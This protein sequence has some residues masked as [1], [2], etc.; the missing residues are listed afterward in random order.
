MAILPNPLDLVPKEL[1]PVRQ[2]RVM[3]RFVRRQLKK[4]GLPPGTVVHVG[5]KKEE[6]SRVS[7][8]DFD[9]AQL[10][11]REDVQDLSVL[12]ALRES[13]TVSWVNVDGLHDTELIERLGERLGLHPLV[14]EDIAHVGQRPKLEEYDEYLYIVL[15]QLEWH[16]E[17]EM[18]AEEQ[19]SLVLGT[20]WMFSFQEQRGDDFDPT[21]E[22][23]RRGQ[24]KLR[25]R[26][27]DYLAYTLLDAT[28]DNYFTILNHIGLVTEQLELELLDDPGQHTMRKLQQLTREL[29]VVRRAVWPLRDV[30]T[31]LM[32]TESE[33]IREDTR[34]YLRDVHDHALR[35]LEAVETLRDVVSG[36]IDLYL[37]QVAHRTN[38]AIKVLT[39]M[40]GIFIPL[41]FI[42]G[43]YGM[44]FVYMP[45]LES[46]WGYPAVWGV[47]IVTAVGLWIR[48]RKRGW[49]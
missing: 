35:V 16:G 19:V 30:L 6:R 1:H 47:M 26:G 14:L 7:F 13:T 29:L 43:V 2:L 4:P 18:V 12:W 41:T 34:F 28:V 45:E 49:V 22:R 11:E 32:R 8:I 25:D 42:V 17:H 38:Q 9:P 46:R 44:N 23:L 48:F 24:A 3:G 15:Y 10:T 31:S 33:L 27:A 39:V 5:A 36:M 21:R 37:S 20:N 40:A